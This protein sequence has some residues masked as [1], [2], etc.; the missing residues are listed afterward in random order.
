M[1]ITQMWRWLQISRTYIINRADHL[2]IIPALRRESKRPL[3]RDG[4]LHCGI[5]QLWFSER[6]LLKKVEN[7]KND[8]WYILAPPCP[9]TPTDIDKRKVLVR[10]KNGLT[11]RLSTLTDLLPSFMAW[12]QSPFTTHMVGRET[13][14][15]EL[16][17]DLH[18]QNKTKK[19]KHKEINRG[20]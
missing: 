2:P 10:N 6:A 19:S 12:V 9:D 13:V 18:I 1:P 3:W 4:C 14:S 20:H 8:A 16:P 17:F 7:N 5:G 15:C 11:G